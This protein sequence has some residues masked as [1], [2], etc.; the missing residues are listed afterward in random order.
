MG[1]ILNS[2]SEYNRCHISRLRVEDEKEKEQREQKTRREHE[3]IDTGLVRSWM[4]RSKEAEKSTNREQ[5][6]SLK[7]EEIRPTRGELGRAPYNRS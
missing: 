3:Q 1:N 5:R 7:E 6:S 4:E 2:K